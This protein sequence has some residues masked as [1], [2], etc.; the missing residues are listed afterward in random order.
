MA[1]IVTLA[2]SVGAAGAKAEGDPIAVY[3]DGFTAGSN[4]DIRVWVAQGNDEADFPDTFYMIDVP[5]MSHE[6]G[7]RLLGPW[8][9]AAVPGDPEYE[10]P[11]EADRY[12]R[13]GRFRWQLGVAD[14]LPGPIK[15]ALRKDRFF[16]IEPYDQTAIDAINSYVIDRAELD[17]LITDTP[18]DP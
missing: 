14:K 3:P 2:K 12:V 11:D 9:R 13:L 8:V 16:V 5:G 15:T 7:L 1:Q 4:E 10:A 17:V 6:T 18:I